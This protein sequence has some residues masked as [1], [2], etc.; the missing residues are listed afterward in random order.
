[1]D[2]TWGKE[3]HR[4]VSVGDA[5]A[6]IA[7]GIR[8]LGAETVAIADAYGRILAGPVVARDDYP[9]FDKAMM[10]GFAVRSPDTRQFLHQ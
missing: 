6:K 10:D 7:D 2:R 8:P 4:L 9:S 3:P 1:M 5:Q